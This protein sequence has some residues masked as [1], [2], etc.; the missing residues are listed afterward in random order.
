MLLKMFAKFSVIGLSGVVVNMAVY[1]PLM[2]MGISYLT[3]AVL[4]FMAAVTNNFVWNLLWTFRGRGADKSFR[5]K[6]ILFVACSI[7]NLVANLMFLKALVEQFG[8]NATVA[9]LIAIGA[10]GVLNFLLNYAITFNDRRSKREEAATTHE[11][12]HYSNL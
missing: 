6:Y 1:V 11:A 7:V 3:A 8:I 5:H 4:S 10:T 9:Q 2:A 12:C